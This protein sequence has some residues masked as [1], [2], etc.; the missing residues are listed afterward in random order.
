[1]DCELRDKIKA[2]I[3]GLV[4]E[5]GDATFAMMSNRIEGFKGDKA[6]EW[7]PQTNI[8][9]WTHLSSEAIG[10]VSDLLNEGIIYGRTTNTL[11]Y[12]HDGGCLSMKVAKRTK[13]YKEPR[14]MPIIFHKGPCPK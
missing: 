13:A 11:V 5:S 2:E 3:V 7:M 1:M 10:A 14:W 6:M 12:L 9:L 8:F 4:E